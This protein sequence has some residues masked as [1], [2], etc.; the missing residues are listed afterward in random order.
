MLQASTGLQAQA[1]AQQR[2]FADA[3]G[4]SRVRIGLQPDGSFGMTLYNAAGTEVVVTPPGRMT[5]P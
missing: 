4:T 3:A 1:T 5:V 2:E